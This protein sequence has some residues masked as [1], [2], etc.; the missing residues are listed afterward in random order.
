[1]YNLLL[2]VLI[3]FQIKLLILL[4]SSVSVNEICSECEMSPWLVQWEW[5]PGKVWSVSRSVSTCQLASTMEEREK[6]RMEV[7]W[8]NENIYPD[9]CLA[10]TN[11]VYFVA[12]QDFW[13]FLWSFQRRDSA[14]VEI[15]RLTVH[16]RFNASLAPPQHFWFSPCHYYHLETDVH[17]SCR[18]KK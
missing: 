12:L 2:L 1:M 13:F 14:K 9:L 8:C 4:W 5:I 15:Q 18:C 6:R 7:L 10:S 11:S 16:L 17:H 3:Q